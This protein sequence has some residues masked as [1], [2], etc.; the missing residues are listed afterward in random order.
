MSNAPQLPPEGAA[1]PPA[2]PAPGFPQ[3]RVA[4]CETNLRTAFETLA[5]E[6]FG[7]T[8]QVIHASCM[9]NGSYSEPKLAAAWWFY[10]RGAL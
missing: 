8:L 9:A 5:A 6:F 10:N 1:R 2:P 3:H 7:R 4:A